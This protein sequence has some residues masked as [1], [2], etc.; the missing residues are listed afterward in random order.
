MALAF[1]RH[2]ADVVVAS[3]KVD[4]CA[5]LAAEI[6]RETG[7]ETLAVRFH[8]GEWEGAEA[9]VDE[10]YGRFGR[11]DVFVNNA[12]MSPLYPSLVE[13]SEELF[14]KVLAVNL[15]GPFRTCALVGERMAAAAGGSIINVS[16]VAAVK[17]EPNALAY[18]CAKAALHTLTLG[19]ARAYG[20]TVR[21]NAIMPGLFRTD[22]SK[23]WGP[24]V[25][26]R[27]T[28]GA[29]PLGRAGSRRR[30]W[31]RR[32]SWRATPEATP[33]AL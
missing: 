10:I 4:A 11:C 27:T 3:R 2:G 19:I 13:M 18:S 21:C 12:G 22:I 20:P 5:A 26:A 16:S 23:A 1:A 9:L 30:S 31:A 15:R 25:V 28:N 8:A 32:C 17:P 6:S 24:D 29:I 33:R 14:D 7:R